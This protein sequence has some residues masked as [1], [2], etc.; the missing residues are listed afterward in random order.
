MTENTP[1]PLELRTT[2]M[3]L[4][5][6][7]LQH[8]DAILTGD[9][10][11][12]RLLDRPAADDW[13]G[14]F[15]AAMDAMAPA[16]AGLAADPGLRPWWMRLFLHDGDRRLIGL[17][18]YK[19]RPDA[20][21]AVEIGYALAPAY[22]GRG[23]A[24]EAARAMAAAAFAGPDVMVVRAHTL[25]EENASTAVLGRLGMRF[26]EALHDPDDGDIWRWSMTRDDLRA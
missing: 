24:I 14:G 22:R 2:R 21:G 23:L 1:P 12:A 19:G 4:L 6:C 9:D 16:R 5:A 10:G 8:F 18:G 11:I 26:E 20:D 3:T 17:G 25:A 7:D 13:M 15:D